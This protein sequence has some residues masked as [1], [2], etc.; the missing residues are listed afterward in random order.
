MVHNENKKVPLATSLHATDAL[1]RINLASIMLGNGMTDNYIQMASIPDYL[2]EGPYPIY[3]DPNGP[4]CQALRAKVPLS[5]SLVKACYDFNFRLICVAAALYCNSQMY[6]PIQREFNFETRGIRH[7]EPFFSLE[8]GLNPY[9]ARRTCDREKDG[10]L[11][12]K[13]MGWIDTYMNRPDIKAALGVNPQRNFESCN[14]AVN[15][16][17]TLQGDSM[18]NTPALLPPMINDGVRL[19]VY[20]GNAGEWDAPI[21]PMA[22]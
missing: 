14:M 12:Y 7:L 4:E 5:Q 9:D 11:C 8:S 3:E 20:A 18:H 10:A 15:M 1:V 16:A 6:G 17:F 22:F 19:L 13:E 21:T 2:C